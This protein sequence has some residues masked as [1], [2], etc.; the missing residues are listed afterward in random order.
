M[1]KLD[2]IETELAE[3]I[4]KNSLDEMVGISDKA[5]AAYLVTS[6]AALKTA[7]RTTNKTKG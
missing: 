3:V 6:L 1:S 4:K 7:H 5:I 2:K